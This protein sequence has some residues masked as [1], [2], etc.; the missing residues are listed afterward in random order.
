MATTMIETK[1]PQGR[2]TY[3]DD[4]EARPRTQT[5]TGFGRTGTG[6]SRRNSM[7]I[8]SIRRR[9]VDPALVLPPQFRTM[10]G[11]PNLFGLGTWN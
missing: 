10:Y 9:S 2:I 7:S 11:C 5:G 4:V 8:Q 1:A 6:L 3:A